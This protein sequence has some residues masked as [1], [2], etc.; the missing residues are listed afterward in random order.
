MRRELPQDKGEAVGRE[1]QLAWTAIIPVVIAAARAGCSIAR[2]QKMASLR[3]P[4]DSVPKVTCHATAWDQGAVTFAPAPRPGVWGQATTARSTSK[5]STRVGRSP[6][7][8]ADMPK[9]HAPRHPS[10]QHDCC[11]R[12]PVADSGA[13]SLL[14]GAI[15]QGRLDQLPKPV[16]DE[17]RISPWET[18]WLGDT[19]FA[20]TL[21]HAWRMASRELRRA[22]SSIRPRSKGA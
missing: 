9:D 8:T 20:A 1:G 10:H 7:S 17:L 15:P 6:Q 5:A 22:S 14:Q 18:S 13:P 12:C 2:R 19:L 11:K 21:A 3:K 4:T 16:F